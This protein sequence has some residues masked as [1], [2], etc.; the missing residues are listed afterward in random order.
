MDERFRRRRRDVRRAQ[1]RRRRRFTVAALTL[2]LLAGVGLAV[3]RSPLFE[4]TEIRVSGT[5]RAGDVRAASGLEPGDNLLAADLDA[6]V[7]GIE[8]LGWVRSASAERRPPSAVEIDVVLRR[9]VAVVRLTDTSWLLD[10]EGVVLSGGAHDDLVAIDAPASVLPAVGVQASDAAVRNALA[11]HAALPADLR[12]RVERYDAASPRGLRLRMTGEDGAP[13]WVR[14]G[15]A[16]RVD[17][18][19]EVI[20]MLLAQ[21]H[22][23]AARQADDAVTGAIELDVRAPDNPVLIPEGS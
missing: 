20:Q 19:A 9:P 14:F 10:D 2:L 15:L 3:A 22:D 8:Q 5:D 1:A 23:Q 16:E 6:A 4:I 13:V 7:A 21:V 12:E 17:T 11:V 18:K